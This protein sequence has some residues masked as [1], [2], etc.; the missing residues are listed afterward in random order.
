M[1]TTYFNSKVASTIFNIFEA[2]VTEW[3]AFDSS[4][5][6][7]KKCI[8]HISREDIREKYLPVVLSNFKK[9]NQSIKI[10]IIEILV[11]LLT[12]NPDYQS[13]QRIHG[14][15]NEELAKSKS[16]YD[17]KIYITLCA[18][19]CP[20]I[21]KKY[22]KEVFAWSFLKISEEKKKD[23]AIIFAKNIIPIRKKLDDISSISK[24]ENCL[25]TFKNLF[26]K[27]AYIVQ[28]C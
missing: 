23:V 18:K 19:L 13:R 8:D 26:N 15:V 11:I 24:I 9:S 28:I 22:F 7:F 6:F 10:K 4:L 16:I 12:K 17:R 25:M 27:D 2:S 1:T 5:E 20:K 14:F 3:R 21:S